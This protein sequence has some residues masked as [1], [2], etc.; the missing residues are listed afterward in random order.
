MLLRVPVKPTGLRRENEL[1]IRPS[2]F[3]NSSLYCQSMFPAT[4][5]LFRKFIRVSFPTIAGVIKVDISLLGFCPQWGGWMD[6]S[7]AG[8]PEGLQ[9]LDTS[10]D[11]ACPWKKPPRWH[12]V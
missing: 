11:R 5:R 6:G 1:P 9:A 3:E 7:F 2:V 12:D 4:T 8:S 10:T